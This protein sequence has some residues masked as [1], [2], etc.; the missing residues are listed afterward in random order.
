MSQPFL[1]KLQ[2]LRA[3]TLLKRDSDRDFFPARLEIFL[4]PYF[5]TSPAAASPG[6]RFPGCNF[7][8]RKTPAKI[9]FCKFYKTFKKIFWQNTSGWLFLLF[10]WEFWDFQ[11]T[12]FIEHLISSWCKSGTRIPGPG[13]SGPWDP[14][15]RNPSKF[16]SGTQ[17]SPKFKS[18]KPRDPLQNLKVGTS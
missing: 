11:N 17:D 16:K 3:P 14:G 6:L 2:I 9:F 10:I 4:R 1:I 18:L 15:R 5:K 8:K 12:S 13:T 7:V